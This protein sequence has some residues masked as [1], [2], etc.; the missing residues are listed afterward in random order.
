MVAGRHDRLDTSL[1]KAV[2]GRLLSKAGM[3]ALRGIAILPGPRLGTSATGPSGLAVKIE[4]GD[5]SDRGTWAA[6]VEAVRQAGLLDAA[7]LRA[8][9]RYHRPTLLDPHGRLGAEAIP[10]FELAPV[11]ELIG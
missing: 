1:M 6:S 8:L 2:P 3:E 7:A 9:A 11:G 4:D 10:E 5:G